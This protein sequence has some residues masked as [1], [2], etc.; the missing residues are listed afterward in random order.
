[1]AGLSKRNHSNEGSVDALVNVDPNNAFCQTSAGPK[2][3]PEDTK[4]F[5]RISQRLNFE[6]FSTG[7]IHVRNCQC[8]SKVGLPEY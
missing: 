8:T 7:K 3:I 6:S 1:M 2:G 4:R 5:G